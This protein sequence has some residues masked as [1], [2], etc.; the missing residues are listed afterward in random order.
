[1]ATQLTPDHWRWA[2]VVIAIITGAL[3]VAAGYVTGDGWLAFVGTA[4]SSGG[5]GGAT[6]MIGTRK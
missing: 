2:A 5:V 6:G 1:M 3:L 4:L